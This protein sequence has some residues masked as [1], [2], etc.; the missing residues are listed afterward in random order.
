MPI[1]A[2]L[3]AHM[4]RILV[5]DDSKTIRTHVKRALNGSG[6]IIAEASNGAE[7]LKLLLQ[8][9]FN[10]VLLDLTMP[11]MDGLAF[12]RMKQTRNDQTPV[13]LLTAERNE[14]LKEA[15]ASPSVMDYLEKP[16]KPSYLKVA[17]HQVLDLLQ[18]ET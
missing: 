12:L 14:L 8:G 6:I 3:V 4:R 15:M 1:A 11:V 9:K 5:A 13:I 18:D 10:L 2:I 7:A 16:L 17:I